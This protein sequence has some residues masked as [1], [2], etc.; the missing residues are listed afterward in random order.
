MKATPGNVI[1]YGYIR[2]ECNALYKSLG[3]KQVAIDPWNA[4]QL[5]VELGQDGLDVQMFRQGFAS[6]AG[7]TK[8]LLRLIE[9]GSFYHDGNP[10]LTWMAGNCAAEIDPAGNM[11][12]SKKK[13]PNKIDGMVAAVMALGL[14]MQH[15]EKTSAYNQKPRF[16][17]V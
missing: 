10:I 8:E 6:M 5:G 15:S 13:S 3:M 11:K 14:L 9:D 7:P 2:K 4:T 1:D 17:A 16:L 12:L